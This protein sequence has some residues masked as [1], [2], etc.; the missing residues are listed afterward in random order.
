[1]KHYSSRNETGEAGAAGTD[2]DQANTSQEIVHFTYFMVR[3][4]AA[5]LGNE[6]RMTGVVERL[7]TGEKRS[8]ATGAEL[9]RLLDDWADVRNLT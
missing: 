7:V 3:L 2:A 4:S 9:I 6:P 5:Q 1:M 8:F